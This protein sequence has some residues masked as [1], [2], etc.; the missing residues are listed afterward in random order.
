[1][2]YAAIILLPASILYLVL[3]PWAKA[4]DEAPNSDSS[5]VATL[6]AACCVFVVISACVGSFAMFHIAPKEKVSWSIYPIEFKDQNGNASIRLEEKF[7]DGRGRYRFY[8]RMNDKRITDYWVR[9]DLVDIYYT[10][11]ADGVVVYEN[12]KHKYAPTWW[13]TFLPM[14]DSESSLNE[15]YKLTIPLGTDI[16]KVK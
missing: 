11:K 8:Y 12:I 9:A 10:D 3:K 2:L 7:A 15:K 4:K 6:T 14:P 13:Y 1:M 16:L 5:S